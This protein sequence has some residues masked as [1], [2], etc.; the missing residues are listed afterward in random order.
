[1][2]ELSKHDLKIRRLQMVIPEKLVERYMNAFNKKHNSEVIEI[3]SMTDISY[4][5]GVC[6]Q[7][8]KHGATIGAKREKDGK[9]KIYKR[10]DCH[11]LIEG[12]TGTG[13]SQGF[14][15]NTLHNLTGEKSV[16][17]TEPKGELTAYSYNYLVSIYGEDNVKILNLRDPT[18]TQLYYNPFK[19]LAE[20]Y[21]EAKN[22]DPEEKEKERAKIVAKLQI[23]IANM[24]PIRDS[25]DS[26]WDLGARDLIFSLVLALCEDTD[27]TFEALFRSELRKKIHPSDITLSKIIEIF[28]RF[29]WHTENGSWGD[30]GFFSSRNN[31]SIAKQRAKTVLGTTSPATRTSYLSLVNSFFEPYFNPKIL[32]ITSDHTVDVLSMAY[33]PK[34]LFILY[35]LSDETQKQ[36]LNNL[37]VNSLTILID[38][39]C[40]TS[41]PLSVP[42]ALF[43]DEF[44]SLTPNNIYVNI[45][46]MGRGM[47]IF[48][49]GII[50]QTLAQL[51]A[52]YKEKTDILLSNCA[53]KI[54][55]GTNNYESAKEFV[56]EVGESIQLSKSNLLSGKISYVEK[57]RL[58]IDKILYQM[59]K[60]ECFVK[61]ENHMPIHSY[62][63]MF[64]K[65]PEYHTFPKF[66]LTSISS[67]KKKKNQ[68]SE[69]KE[70]YVSKNYEEEQRIAMAREELERR[71]AEI[72]KRMK[73]N[74]NNEEEDECEEIENIIDCIK[75][76]SD[77]EL[78]IIEIALKNGSISENWLEK[79]FVWGENSPKELIERF[80]NLGIIKKASQKTYKF[81]FSKQSFQK[82]CSKLN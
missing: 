19:V 31:A 11:M 72:L 60:G 20:K 57:P 38:E 36:L 26:S 59:K 73:E 37:I 81:V 22:L 46:A 21:Y 74:E 52:S 58:S 6:Q 10:E 14:L 33:T 78:N 27:D 23:L 50:V 53:V 3:D 76:L 49:E 16:I 48:L 67:P 30:L 1:M 28:S 62:F 79:F 70:M 77:N 66:D 42:V 5:Y 41:K 18:K 45:C 68:L 51:R 24:F 35:D 69:D 4:E 39:Y 55:L 56:T 63:E 8:F 40:K 15:L 13:K 2:S 65:T 43:L 64:Y 34:V 61:V 75:Y 47:N 54:F 12:S 32:D 29:S 71:K 82:A 17:V 44:D 25:R 7:N 80:L 9:L